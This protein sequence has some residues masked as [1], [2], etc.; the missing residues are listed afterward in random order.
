LRTLTGLASAARSPAS[1]LTCGICLPRVPTRRAKYPW[2]A[3]TAASACPALSSRSAIPMPI[4][5]L[6]IP[7]STT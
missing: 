2:Y 5:T 7:E 6:L 3:V 1:S 4:A